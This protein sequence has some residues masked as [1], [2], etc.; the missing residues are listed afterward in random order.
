MARRLRQA[1]VTVDALLFGRCR[2]YEFDS[3][4][5]MFDQLADDVALGIE[6][7]LVVEEQAPF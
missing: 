6:E 1:Q 7:K 3:A 2:T 5:L 4:A